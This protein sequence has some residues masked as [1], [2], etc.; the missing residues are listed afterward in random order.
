MSTNH[1]HSEEK[2]EPKRN[3]SV[4]LLLA[5]HTARHTHI[6]VLPLGQTGSRII[7]YVHGFCIKTGRSASRHFHVSLI[8]TRAKVD[9]EKDS[10]HT[11]NHNTT[12]ESEGELKRNRTD[13]R[14]LTILKHYRWAKSSH[15]RRHSPLRC[16]CSCWSA[17]RK[18]TVVRI[19]GSSRKA[20]TS[21]SCRKERQ[22]RDETVSEAET[23]MW[24]LG[25]VLMW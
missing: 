13:I 3:R 10:V 15:G 8:V 11:I 12:T 25:A 5:S 2:G 22:G 19:W 21:L 16:L 18:D 23:R 4:A 1:N 9:L 6:N 7:M 20:G 24:V 14:L 17:G